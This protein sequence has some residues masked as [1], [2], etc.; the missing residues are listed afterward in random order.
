MRCER[1]EAKMLCKV[2]ATGEFCLSESNRK[3]VIVDWLGDLACLSTPL[4]TQS[5]VGAAAVAVTHGGY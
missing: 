1:R 3:L 4:S 5:A 2:K